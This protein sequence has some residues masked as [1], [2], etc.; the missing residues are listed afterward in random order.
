MDNIVTLKR[1][2]DNS[3]RIVFFTGA[4]ISVPSGIPD[5]RSAG[6]LYRNNLRAEEML[7]HEFFE[8]YPEEFY[9]FYFT[10]MVYLKAKP[11]AAHLWIEELKKDHDVKVV[12]QNIDGLHGK[13]AYE[14]HGSIYRNY[15]QKCHRFYSLAE[16]YQKELPRCSCGG[17]IKPDVVLYGEPL[18]ADV[19][20]KAIAAIAEADCLIIIGTS[21]NV[22]PAASFINYFGGSHLIVINKE[23]YHNQRADLVFNEDVIKVVDAYHNLD[24]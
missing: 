2:I 4:G 8:N 6:G 11:N 20:D 12:T 10:K 3:R 18:N 1:I 19:V 17:I 22:Y 16:I 23:P 21:L 7:S 15:C 5:F 9:R 13:D 14:L 24:K